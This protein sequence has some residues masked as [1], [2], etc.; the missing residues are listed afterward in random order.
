MGMVRK[1]GIL[2]LHLKKIKISGKWMPIHLL[3]MVWNG[4]FLCVLMEPLSP[5]SSTVELEPA[6]TD[7]SKR[8]KEY[9]SCAKNVALPHH[10][11]T[12]SL[13][14]WMLRS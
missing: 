7:D 11:T 14:T 4:I 13:G 3:E 1:P 12:K 9:Q 8:W 6:R 2:A 5:Y 10:I